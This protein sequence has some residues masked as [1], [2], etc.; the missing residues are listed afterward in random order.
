MY[1]SM[2][3]T[4]ALDPDALGRMLWAEKLKSLRHRYPTDRG[5]HRAYDA[6]LGDYSFADRTSRG[7]LRLSGLRT[8]DPGATR[9]LR[10]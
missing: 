4:I 1:A 10:W 9:S 3:A 8:S 5:A 7:L 6:Q 2:G